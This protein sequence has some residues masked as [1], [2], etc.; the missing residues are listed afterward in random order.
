MDGWDRCS[1]ISLDAYIKHLFILVEDDQTF[2]EGFY[3]LGK[4]LE[5]NEN[6]H[7]VKISFVCAK[8]VSEKYVE[9]EGNWNTDKYYRE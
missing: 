2:A 9:S 7:L 4:A 8:M 3:L 5:S 6:W 1:F